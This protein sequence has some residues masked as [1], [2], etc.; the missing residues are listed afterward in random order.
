MILE[1]VK[2]YANF[3][4]YSSISYGTFLVLYVKL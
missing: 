3:Y 2:L 4:A 1:N